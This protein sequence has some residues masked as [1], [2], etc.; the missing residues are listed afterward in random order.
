MIGEVG[1]A[2]QIQGSLTSPVIRAHFF[3]G[4]ALAATYSR[5]APNEGGPLHVQRSSGC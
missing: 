5:S 1:F 2:P 4:K 3:R